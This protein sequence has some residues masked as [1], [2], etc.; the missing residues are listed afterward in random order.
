MFCKAHAQQKSENYQVI[1]TILSNLRFLARQVYVIRGDGN[2]H[3]SNFIQLFML[4]GE[5]NP[6]IYEWML[7]HMD[8]YNSHD[9]QNDMVKKMAHKVL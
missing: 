5:D 2:D 9:M 1:L 8:K 6:M 3:N 7:K 4:R